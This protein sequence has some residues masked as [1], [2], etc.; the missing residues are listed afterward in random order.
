MLRLS[1]LKGTV[2]KMH[3]VL[4]IFNFL[5]EL[6]YNMDYF[7]LTPVIGASSVWHLI[8]CFMLA[9]TLYRGLKSQIPKWQS[10][11]SRFC[12]LGGAPMHHFDGWCTIEG[13]EKIL[14]NSSLIF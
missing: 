7:N 1:G 6:I 4:V 14:S 13:T 11:W 3:L 9:L 8:R 2:R 10:G 5:G 12:H